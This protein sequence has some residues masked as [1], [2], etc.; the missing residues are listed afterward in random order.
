MPDWTKKII[1]TNELA[2]IISI[3][4][5]LDKNSPLVTGDHFY[6]FFLPGVHVCTYIFIK[7][8]SAKG[9]LVLFI[10]PVL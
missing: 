3:S 10:K 6:T 4:C 9:C 5:E 1:S 2:K 7:L 8:I